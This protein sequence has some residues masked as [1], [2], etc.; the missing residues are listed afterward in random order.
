MLLN[1]VGVLAVPVLL[2]VIMMC[3]LVPTDPY[4]PTL[5]F[6]PAALLGKTQTAAL[7]PQVL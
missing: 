4:P 6:P 7:V 3:A 1:A 5:A 2:V